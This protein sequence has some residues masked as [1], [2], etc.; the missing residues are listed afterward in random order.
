MSDLVPSNRELHFEPWA[1]NPYAWDVPV[2]SSRT[3]DQFYSKIWPLERLIS[4]S[5]AISSTVGGLLSFTLLFLVLFRT[6]GELRSYSRMLLLSCFADLSFW[7]CGLAVEIVSK[8]Q[9]HGVVT[10]TII[11]SVRLCVRPVDYIHISSRLLTEEQA[12]RRRLLDRA[13]R[14]G[15]FSKLRR[16]G[17]GHDHLRCPPGGHVLHS[18]GPV[19][20][21][22]PC[23]CQVGTGRVFS[24]LN[25]STLF[26]SGHILPLHKTVL[27]YLTSLLPAVMMAVISWSAYRYSGQSRPGFNYATLWYEQR[28]VPTLIIGDIVRGADR[29]DHRSETTNGRTQI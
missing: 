14:L 19:L 20:L 6:Q 11:L 4:L 7:L 15:P 21:P 9:R 5:Y 2:N 10:S 1:M 24:N 16:P 27:L 17:D 23:H 26:S 18:A 29:R 22:L 28:P 3:E 13:H 12:E 25:G 8:K